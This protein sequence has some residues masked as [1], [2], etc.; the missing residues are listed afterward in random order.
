MGEFTASFG[1]DGTIFGVSDTSIQMEIVRAHPA[2]DGGANEFDQL[3]LY[4]AVQRGLARA[5]GP[6][7]SR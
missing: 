7:K 1:E 5:S 4:P 6:R 2:S 3:V